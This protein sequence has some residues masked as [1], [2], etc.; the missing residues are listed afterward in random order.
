MNHLQY[1]YLLV[2]VLLWVLGYLHTG[3]LV[4]PRWKQPGK[5]VFYLTISVAL[6]Y[7]FDHYALFFIILHPLLGLV[8]HIRVCRR[9]HINWKTCQPREKYIELQE[10]WAKGEF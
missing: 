3:K 8:F 7:W 5:A 2:A 10:K 9:H 1:I 4:R 6:I